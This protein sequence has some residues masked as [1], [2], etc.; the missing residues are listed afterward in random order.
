MKLY[1]AAGSCSTGIRIL[2]ELAGAPY[3]L[4][5]LSLA[6]AEQRGPDYLARNP[7]GKVP[8]LLRPDGSLLTE[9]PVISQWIAR[10]FPEAGLIPDGDAG[11]RALELVEHV[12]STLHM[13]GSVFAMRPAK[14]LADPSAQEA[15]R[16]HGQEVVAEGFD[17]L[18]ADLGARDW[19]FDRPGIADAAVFYL[20]SWHGPVGVTPPPALL[21]FLDRMR[22]LE[23]VRRS[24]G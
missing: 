10:T 2:L 24:L 7:K 12:V 18:A 20:T 22:G 4:E 11:W 21:A 1:H 19:F 6:A 15:L 8:A 17:R 5:T 16:R 14:F 3:Q 13:R 23:A 9:Y